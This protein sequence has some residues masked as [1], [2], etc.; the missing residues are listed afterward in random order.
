M[1]TALIIGASRGIGH[2]FARQYRA[3]G[4]RVIATA[5]TAEQLAELQ[6]MGC[7][8]HPLDVNNLNDCA[9]LGWRLD[10]EK[11]DVAIFNAGVFGPKTFDLVTPTEEQFNQV[12]HT[13][14]FAAMRILPILLPLVENANGKLAV[15]SSDMGSISLRQNADGWLYRASK[16]ALNSVLRDVSLSTS[17]AVCVALHPGWVKTDMGGDGAKLDVEDSVAALRGVLASLT[18]ADNS[19]FLSFNGDHLSW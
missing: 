13:N 12:M 1:P 6:A 5:R 4:W 19:A 2:E 3:I 11:L 7:E 10:D 15:I 18:P 14:V 16:T 17:Q 8:A 9:G